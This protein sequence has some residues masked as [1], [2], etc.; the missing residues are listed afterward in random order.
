[1]RKVLFLL[2]SLAIGVSTATAKVNGDDAVVVQSSSPYS[3]VI[4]VN[5]VSFKMIWVEGGTF[6][7]G[8]NDGYDDEQPIHAVTL[9]GYWIAETEV[10][11]ALWKA[12]MGSDEGWSNDYGKGSNYPAYDVSY[13][14]AVDFCKRL[15][16]LTDYKYG[17]RLPT[18]AEWEYAARGGKKSNGY[19]YSGS[20]N[21]DDVAWYVDNSGYVAHPVKS[22]KCNELGLY[23]MSG[24]LW[25]WCSDWYSSSYYS[26]SPSN[27]PTGPKSGDYRVLRGGGWSH[28]ESGCR[29]ADRYYCIPDCSIYLFGFRV[30]SSLSLQ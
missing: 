12:V 11:Q 28:G 9:D 17:F 20:N 22:K 1:M 30:A 4:T 6:E 10:T 2:L 13:N 18:E 8:S 26:N 29:V 25:E 27:N 16:E 14:E 21:I 7:M 23:D 24:N 15:N 5:G 19:K 3:E